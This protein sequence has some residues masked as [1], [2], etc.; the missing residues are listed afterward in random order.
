VNIYPDS[1]NSLANQQDALSAYADLHHMHIVKTYSDDGKSGLTAENRP[2][3]L[4]LLHD[5][6]S[7][8][9]RFRGGGLVLNVTSWGR[10]QNTGEAAYHEFPGVQRAQTC[11]GR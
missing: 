11:H 1:W 3:L 9:A 4:S 5:I 6:G 7:G 10:F 2:G 8:H